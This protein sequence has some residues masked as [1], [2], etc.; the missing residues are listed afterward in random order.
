MKAVFG[1]LLLFA[2]LI[3]L[4]GC[5]D[6]KSISEQTNNTD[7]SLNQNQNSTI[8]T[9]QTAS[10]PV[11]NNSVTNPINQTLLP[12]ETNGD[13]LLLL[14]RSV[15]QGWA[16]YMGLQWDDNGT[17]SG[18]YEGYRIRRYEVE[19]PPGIADSAIAGMETFDSKVVFFKLCF[20]D[21]GSEQNEGLVENEQYVQKV[22]DEAVTKRGKK[23][24]VGNAL[25]QTASTSSDGLRYNHKAYNKWLN[26]FASSHKNIYVLDLYGMLI[27]SGGN[28]RA[29]YA[30][31]S[32]DSHLNDAAYAKI[33]PELMKLIKKAETE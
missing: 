28:L 30:I 27:D 25:P 32:D 9:N 13:D 4:F 33:T 16:D 19:S 23:L 12:L 8:E 14:G 3:L 31:S 15:S 5:V 1:I 2:S 24:I 20:V 29:D 11:A 26:D 10:E 7:T 6:P 22:Y 21:F 17:M 18:I